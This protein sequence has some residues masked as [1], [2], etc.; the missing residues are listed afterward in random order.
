MKIESDGPARMNLVLDSAAKA[1]IDAVA[2]AE[3][4]AAGKVI[5]DAMDLYIAKMKPDDRK[6]VE[7]L[8]QRA[9][10]GGGQ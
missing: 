3:R 7:M 4:R 9:A 2:T 10:L 6:L 8:A 1:K 5:A